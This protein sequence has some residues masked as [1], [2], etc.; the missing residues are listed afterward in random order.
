MMK[1]FDL[2]A[3]RMKEEKKLTGQKGTKNLKIFV[4]N[5]EG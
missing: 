3:N 1:V 2:L 5:T 4:I